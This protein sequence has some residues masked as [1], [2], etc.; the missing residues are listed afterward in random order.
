MKYF[1]TA[2]AFVLLAQAS[3]QAEVIKPN[4]VRATSQFGLGLNV[5]NLVNGDQG[6]AVGLTDYGLVAEGGPGVLDDSHRPNIQMQ[7]AYGWI[8]GCSDA[9]IPGGDPGVDCSANVFAVSPEEEQIVEFQFD[10][11]YDLSAMYIWNEN[12]EVS[13]LDRGV[14]E[15]ELQV[16]TQRVGDTFTPAGTFNLTA[17]DGFSNNYAQM[18]SMAGNGIRRVRLLVNSRHGGTAEDYVGLAEVRFEGT[19]VELDLAA[20]GDKDDDVDGADF[21]LL[22]RGF[23]FGNLDTFLGSTLSATQSEG[24]YDNNNVVNGD[25]IAA[26]A[27]EYGLP[28]PLGAAQFVPEPSTLLLGFLALLG[29]FWRLRPALVR[30]KS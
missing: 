14:N 23:G 20:D 15:F 24:D 12:D 19:L 1:A 11:S 18:I 26:W 5:E 21:L 9:G 7:P 6:A 13:A 17:D 27:N 16:S 28:A 2:L 8:S 30:V 4:D 22:Q 3:L 10:G 29:G 25:D